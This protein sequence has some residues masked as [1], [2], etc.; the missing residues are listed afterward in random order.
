M[1]RDTLS[2]GSSVALFL[3]LFAAMLSSA[4]TTSRV[5]GV[6]RDASGALISGAQVTLTDE[7]TK[8][9]FTGETTSAGTYV[10]D[11]VKPGTYTVRI[12]K[13][14]FKT[15][16]SNGNVVTIGQPTALTTSLQVGVPTE[17]MVVSGAADLVQTATSGN[18]G[19]LVDSVALNTL[20]IVTSRG[21]NTLS[22]VE[23]EPGVTDSGGFNQGGPNV[24]G[25]GV[26]ANGARD[27]AWNYTLD[28]IDINET[29]AGG[30]NFSP[31]RT[32]PD[33]LSEFRVVTSNFTSEYG[34]NSG[35][36][37]EMV[38]RSGTNDYHGSAYFFY[39]TPGL[40]A[41]DPA[42]KEQGFGRPQFIQKIP[43]FTF[44][45][46]IFKNKTFFFTNF[47][48]L[49]TLTTNL[50]IQPVYTQ[51]ARNGIFRFIDQ[52]SPICNKDPY[53]S[54]CFNAGFG[55]DN[56]TVDASGNPLP[57]VNVVTY[58]AVAND[59]EAM[60]LDPSV[61]QVVNSAPLPND[62]KTGEGLNVAAFDW[63]AAEHEQQLDY[64][65]R[66]DH[67]FNS[68]HSVFVRWSAGHQNTIGDTANLGLPIFPGTPNVV[69]TFRTP[70]NL[71]VSWRWEIKP[72]LLNELVV[73]LNRFGFNF[74]NPDPNFRSNP[75]F[76]F[77][78]DPIC[79]QNGIACMNVPLQ[80]YVGNARFLTTY[81]L[82]DN[83]S[84]L[85]GAHAF[86]WGLNF[87]YQ[88]HIDQRGNIGVLDA[89]LAV[90]FDPNV[91]TVDSGAFKIPD[92]TVI[93]QGNDALNLQGYINGLLGR[94]GSI[95]QGFVPQ[96]PNTW[97]PPGTI[98]HADFRMPEY[99]FYVQDSWRVRPNLVVD[100]GLRWEIK[101]SPRV[102]N[103]NNMLRPD[104][105]I[106]WGFSSD[107]LVWKPGQLYR[108]SYHDLGPSI[109]FAW[110]PQNNGKTSVRGNFR[111]A[112]DRMNTFA[113]SSA[114]FQG[115]PG[116]STQVTD[117]AFGSA[118]GRLSKLT[119]EVLTGIFNNYL[120]CD[121]CTPTGLRQ[122][123]PFSNNSNT[124]VSPNWR[125]P[126]TYMWSLGIQRELP[127]KIVWETNYLG[128][129]AV[130]LFGAYD[131]NQAK[132][133]EN[134][135][136]DA[137]KTVAG[138]DDSPLMDQ[139]LASIVPDGITGSEWLHD[140][141]DK[142]SPFFDSSNPYGIY[143]AKGAVAGLAANAQQDQLP[144]TSGL[145]STFFYSYPQF[146]GSFPGS[147]GGFVVL[148]SSDFSTYH[149]L[150]T[151]VR[152]SFS[153][154]FTFQASYVWSKSMDT[155]SFDPTFTT[156][157]TAS[158]PFGASSTPFDL[159]HRKANYAPSD[160]DRTHSFQSI[161]VYELPFGHGKRWGQGWN[162]FLDRALGGWEIGGFAIIQ[163]G[164]PTT[165]FS[166]NNDYTL[167]SV[168]RTVAN[169]D[170]CSP[171]MF[172]IHRNPDGLLSYVTQDQKDKF[173]TPGP[174]EFSNVGRNFFRLAGYK[175]LSMSIGKKTRI[176]ERQQLELR[177]EI[178]NLTNSV[179]YDEPGSNR[180][181]NGDFGI[182]DPATVVGDGRGLTSDPRK[183][184]LSAKYSF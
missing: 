117:Q 68:R 36:Q 17:T 148:D 140:L 95:Q 44:G 87:R 182:V 113:L 118:H 25:G 34:R 40:N 21:R 161:W 1:F 124:V 67:T 50:N 110:D 79:A 174:G 169:C 170:Q 64:T 24:A 141:N 35:A 157:A 8:V 42:S 89:A 59:P 151:Q 101:L 138:G 86:K 39:Q 60:G 88:R 56:A 9:A 127:Y 46:P 81:Q 2:L 176:T 120:T 70:K 128:R 78:A 153:N 37:V 51:Q 159:D 62:F 144:I 126:Q 93:D 3:L 134:G 133:R 175:N 178:Q 19:N 48:W 55:S 61:Q 155:R 58:D 92:G 166:N 125:P 142:S 45:G 130:H 77:F 52:N 31:L 13:A 7:A 22:L 103:A 183:M 116:L 84:Y 5:T 71:A 14:G 168:V 184:Q 33:M 136:L 108:D 49:R 43:G 26:H 139:L 102:T 74:A 129:R 152:R 72:T 154:G 149:A 23:L 20:P 4:Q 106:G 131:A 11:A 83:M 90:N 119:P 163:S 94:V 150:Q 137:F 172:K 53:A 164:R 105:P 145:G 146:S 12:A 111:I 28:G 6:V 179:H 115:M 54:N 66:V 65:V 112:F 122:P 32:N 99:D 18:I 156:V 91:N 100:L 181:N 98:L 160:F 96:D 57:G 171:D 132:I 73:G 80:N 85:H 162:G 123:P 10:F 107:S 158:S 104:G 147:P 76:N 29:S 75:V 15:F 69:D 82:A 135:F 114:I 121:G 143:F 165:V 16:E 63:L 38:T 173:S 27:R 30:S 109:G 177:L 167:S 47:Q 180:Y 97:A 41:N